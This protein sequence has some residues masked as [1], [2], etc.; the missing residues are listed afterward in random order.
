MYK[1]TFLLLL[2]LFNLTILSQSNLIPNG[3][4]EK[5]EECPKNLDYFTVSDWYSTLSNRTTPD[6]FSRCADSSS[7]ASPDNYIINIK[8][9]KGNSYGGFVGFNPKN[10]YREYMSVTL[11]EKLKKGENYTFSFALA[12]P[13][14]SLHYI[15][16]LGVFF[17]SKKIDLQKVGNT[18]I[19]KAHILIHQDQFLKCANQ[20]TEYS[21]D[22]VARGGEKE[23]HLGCF[24]TDEKLIYRTYSER[25]KFCGNLNFNDAYYLI[26]EVHLGLKTKIETQ[27]STLDSLEKETP[28]KTY[29]YTDL[30]FKTGAATSTEVTYKD[31]EDL[32]LFLKENPKRIFLIEGHTDNVGTPEDNLELSKS[33]AQFVQDYLL[34]K[35]IEKERSSTIGYGESQPLKSNESKIGRLQNRRV[36]VKVYE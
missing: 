9:F 18:L 25:R 17:T 28:I 32:I 7:F 30:N 23:L 34:K 21:F 4:F 35:G 5:Q 3:G 20:W 12:Q 19:A 33:R 27:T 14:M 1:H 11:T 24:L 10:G 15:S 26:D 2:L 13:D 29:I 6:Y 36:V 31:F 8:P 22:Y 16:D